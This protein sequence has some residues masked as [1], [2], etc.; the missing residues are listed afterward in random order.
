MLHRGVGYLHSDNTTFFSKGT[1]A[2]WNMFVLSAICKAGLV[3]KCGKSQFGLQSSNIWD[4]RWDNKTLC[5]I[6]SVLLGTGSL[7]EWRESQVILRIIRAFEEHTYF[8]TLSR[9]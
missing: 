8:K 1:D 2:I 9:S 3:V 7:P 6:R 4:R 5:K